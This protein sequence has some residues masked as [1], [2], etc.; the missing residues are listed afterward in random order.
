MTFPAG[1]MILRGRKIKI[2][3]QLLTKEQSFRMYSVDTP[4]ERKTQ[5]ICTVD[6]KL[7]I[8]RCLATY[9]VFFDDN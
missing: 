4:K 2:H 3:I 1:S 5:K 8:N 7:E 9:L 6:T